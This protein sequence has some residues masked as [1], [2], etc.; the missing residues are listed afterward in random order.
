[1]HKTNL[2]KVWIVV[3]R[4]ITANIKTCEFARKPQTY[5]S[6]LLVVSFSS[7]VIVF[8]SGVCLGVWFNVNKKI[9][10]R[11]HLFNLLGNI[12]FVKKGVHV[13]FYY[14]ILKCFCIIYLLH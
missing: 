9:E 10:A 13:I 14:G 5:L 4:S 7:F 8:F 11:L 12:N 1:M 2:I 3:L 6:Y